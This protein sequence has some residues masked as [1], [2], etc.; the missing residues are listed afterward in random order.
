VI[1]FFE[2]EFL[3][4]ASE[5][6]GL[7]RFVEE[8]ETEKDHLIEMFF[9]QILNLHHIWLKRLNHR[10]PEVEEM[11]KMPVEYWVQLNR[12]NHQDT[13]EFLKFV[14]WTEVFN[15]S[16]SEM[17]VL[18]ENILQHILK[19]SVFLRGRIEQRLLELN[20]PFLSANYVKTVIW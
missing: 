16:N 19:Q 14:D 3:K 9:S 2:R 5:M 1:D 20:K 15:R 4:N 7:I 6:E 13:F 8:S 10:K 12:S 11:D 18:A 17:N